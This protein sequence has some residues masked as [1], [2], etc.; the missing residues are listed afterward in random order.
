MDQIG[1]SRYVS[2][3]ERWDPAL[4]IKLAAQRRT[5]RTELD[6][7]WMKDWL[8]AGHGSSE[9]KN[10]ALTLSR[11]GTTSQPLRVPAQPVDHTAGRTV[12]LMPQL[13]LVA[14]LPHRAVEGGRRDLES[15]LEHTTE[16]IRALVSHPVR[17][18]LHRESGRAQ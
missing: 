10:G 18:L 1:S 6:R 16:R 11:A 3:F 2:L 12:H 5:D 13:L 8:H 9:G 17:Y 15:S 7:T 14:V 4:E